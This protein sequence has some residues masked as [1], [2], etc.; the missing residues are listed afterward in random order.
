MSG[1]ERVYMFMM[2]SVKLSLGFLFT[3][4][5]YAA[6]PPAVLVAAVAVVV[7]LVMVPAPSLR[8]TAREHTRKGKRRLIQCF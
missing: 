2:L 8:A 4:H 3:G 5:L 7:P 1:A 6:A